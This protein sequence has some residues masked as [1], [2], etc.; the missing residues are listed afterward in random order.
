MLRTHKDTASFAMYDGTY[1]F[2]F[3]RIF[4]GQK[5][6]AKRNAMNNI[7]G[8]WTELFYHR[9]DG[10]PYQPSGFMVTF[11]SL[12]GELARRGVRY[13]L[14]KDF[15][16]RGGFMRDLELRWNQHKLLD[17]TFAAIQKSKCQRI[18]QKIYEQQS[19]R[20]SWT[21]RTM[22]LIVNCCLPVHVAQCWASGATR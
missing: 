2:Q 3:Y 21:L 12:F 4:Q 15:N 1:D 9:L 13:S 8:L 5:T 18:T 22:W 17:D 16:Y 14:S 20:A 11:H 19:R 7:F 10:K 6:T